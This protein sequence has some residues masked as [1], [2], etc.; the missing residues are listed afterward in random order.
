MISHFD[1]FLKIGNIA[2]LQKKTNNLSYDFDFRNHFECSS[3][4][5]EID[6]PVLLH[7]GAVSDYA[8]T[9][10][11]LEKMGFKVLIRNSEHLRCSNIEK[12]YP[13]LKEKTPFTKVYDELPPLEV[14]Q[15]DFSFPVFIKG[16]RQTNHH[17]KS[18]CIINDETEYEA[19]RK[20]WKKDNILFWQKAAVREYVPLQIV[21]DTSF[22]DMVPISYEFRF[23][24]FEGK[25]MGYGPY[26]TIG[27][28]Y[29][30][31]ETELH[32]VLKLTDW[33]AMHLGV[34][35]PAID[36]AKTSAGEWIIIEVNDAQESG[37]AGINPIILWNNT[38]EAMQNRNWIP[39]EELFGDFIE[40]GGVIMGPDPLHGMSLEEMRKISENIS[41]TNELIAVYAA[42]HNKF[43]VVED[44]IY[45]YEIGTKE[46][47]KAKA[48]IDVWEELMVSLEKRVISSAKNEGLMDENEE[49]PNSIK[50]LVPIMTK[51]GYQD[52]RGW[53]VKN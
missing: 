48:M 6:T 43:W 20:E 53:W 40:N 8:E 21:D 12:W 52:G 15:K 33:A 32:E 19:L 11:T 38:I 22:P 9:E 13:V 50:A 18:Q 16:N 35:F 24:Y 51:Y 27:K 42:V 31:S 28:P 4:V 45:D 46:Y 30:I 36:V 26:W 34:S 3:V 2:I 41:D 17:K 7:I 10:Q 37:F 1:D 49:H 25:C 23:F 44:D 39:V 5:S 47:E 14:L 29:T